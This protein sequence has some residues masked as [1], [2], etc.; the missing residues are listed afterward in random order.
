MQ[1]SGV[2]GDPR[3]SAWLLE[4]VISK[5]TENAPCAAEGTQE[6]DLRS[7][8]SAHQAF[9]GGFGDALGVP[10]TVLGASYL[11]FGALVRESDLTVWQGVFST[12]TGWALPGQIILIELYYVGAPLLLIAFAVALTNARLLPM[13]VTLM[14]YLRTPGL[15]RWR[16][17]FVAHW[18]AVTGWAQALRVCPT[19]VP[20]ERWHYFFGFT[21]VLWPAT[22]LATIVGFF[23][24]AHLPPALSM[25]LVFLNPIYF[26]LVFASDLSVR[27]RVLAMVFGAI[28]GPLTFQWDPDW[29]LLLTGFLAGSLGFALGYRRK[30]TEGP[31]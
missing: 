8:G 7:F 31:T 19:L 28:L 17:Y 22:I 3:L 6:T 27:P 13:A 21:M 14:P 12:I 20:E 5:E 29:A 15:K 16:Y 11:G 30:K 4:A 25:G 18:V 26:M 23:L 1:L 9:K 2:A 24:A 10:A